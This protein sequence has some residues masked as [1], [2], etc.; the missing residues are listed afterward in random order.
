MR[1]LYFDID[2]V[3]LD[4][5][6]Q[7]RILLTDGKLEEKIKGCKFDK[8]VCVSG[9]SHIF[10]ESSLKLT[11]HQQK[12]NIYLL[13]D[14]IFTDTNWFMDKLELAHD[15]DH[16]AKQL[17]LSEDWYYIDEWA[18]KFFSDEYGELMFDSE[19]GKRILLVEPHGDGQ[20]ILDFFGTICPER[21][22]SDS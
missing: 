6:D 18:D 19:K 4:Y 1:I 5:N 11:T 12:V 14:N 8:L 3:F 16:R 10:N 2:S 9:W 21:E 7:Q 13:L 20:D 22:K 15:T 17:S